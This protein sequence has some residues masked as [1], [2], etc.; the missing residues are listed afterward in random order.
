MMPPSCIAWGKN[1]S[2]VRLKLNDLFDAP[3]IAAAMSQQ[4]NPPSNPYGGYYVTDWTQQHANFFRACKWRS[5]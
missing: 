1:V 4:L 3:T 5:V 2:G